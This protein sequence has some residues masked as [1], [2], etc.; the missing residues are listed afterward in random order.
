MDQ[1]KKAVQNAG[2]GVYIKFP[3]S[4]TLTHSHPVGKR[5]SNYT[6]EI[7]ALTSASL[8]L[9]E[10]REKG[11]NVVFLTDSKSALQ[12]VLAGPS[13]ASTRQLLENINLLSEHNNVT[14]Q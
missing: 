12:A 5:C 9:S 13:D 8:K 7:Q 14:L 1:L 6:A 11:Q 4:S 2:T 3:D 10:Q